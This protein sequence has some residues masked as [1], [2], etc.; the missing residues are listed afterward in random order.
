M[1][2]D[3]RKIDRFLSNISRLGEEFLDERF[4]DLAI[5]LYVMINRR[6]IDRL[7]QERTYK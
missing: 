7:F 5:M 4:K 2:I 6:G 1:L 3:E